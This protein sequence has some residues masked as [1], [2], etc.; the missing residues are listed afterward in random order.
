MALRFNKTDALSGNAIDGGKFSL[1]SGDA[2]IKLRKV[3]DGV[4]TPDSSGSTTFTTY[5]DTALI[6]PL[7]VG[8]YTI[9]EEQAPAGY[10]TTADVTATVTESST[11]TSPAVAAM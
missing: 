5:N 7:A 1:Y 2:L 8:S 9:S 6:A 4:Y 11:S 3:E 10:A